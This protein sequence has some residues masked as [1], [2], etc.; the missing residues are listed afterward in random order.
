MR[1]RW[2]GFELP[3]EVV[4]ERETLTLTYGK[5]IVEPFERGFGTTIGNAL[6]RVLL[7]S[8][9]GAAI[10]SVKIEGVHHQFSTMPGVVED[11]TD[12]VLNLKGVLL[13]MHTDNP[14]VLKINKKGSGILRAGDI[15]TDP[16]VKIVN[17]NHHIA[18][19]SED[20][21]FVAELTCRRGRGYASAAD[22]EV[23]PAEIGVIPIDAIFSSVR[24]VRFRAEETRVGQVT[25]YD[26]LVLE[27]WTDGT[28]TPDAALVEGAKILRKHFDPFITHFELGPAASPLL[29]AA[30][31]TAAPQQEQQRQDKPIQLDD[32]TERKLA[33]PIEELNL[34]N[35]CLNCLRAENILTVRD[36]LNYTEPQLL[37]LRNFGTTS[38]NEVKTRL[39]ELGLSLGTEVATG[40]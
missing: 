37:R 21:S 2:R 28:V 12:I 3:T 29:T 13:T 18:T 1:S 35:R 9:E 11:V 6:R 5:F 33:L 16:D 25:N 24:R 10:T 31:S 8:L 22:N 19:L 17:P 4:C 34:S 40:A 7:S 26:R 30:A 20:V 27:I 14:K 15:E 23:E 39:E 36:L 32:E 38:L